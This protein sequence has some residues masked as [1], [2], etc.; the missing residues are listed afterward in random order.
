[1]ALQV[2]LHQQSANLLFLVVFLDILISDWFSDCKIFQKSKGVVTWQSIYEVVSS[3]ATVV[4]LHYSI[5]KKSFWMFLCD[6]DATFRS[7]MY[8]TE[9][10]VFR[11]RQ[12]RFLCLWLYVCGKCFRRDQQKHCFC[13][14][15]DK[16]WKYHQLIGWRSWR[17]SKER[18]GAADLS[19]RHW[20]T[21]C[22]PLCLSSVR[23]S[24]SSILT[25]TMLQGGQLGRHCGPWSQQHPSL[26][27]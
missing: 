4:L 16:V 6:H 27:K 26:T 25:L 1:M 14:R 12:T 22:Y 10:S 2:R 18:W 3:F 7:G 23:L 9:L 17:R 11:H 13:L 15:V 5:T 24:S 19:N 21:C 8:M 20:Q